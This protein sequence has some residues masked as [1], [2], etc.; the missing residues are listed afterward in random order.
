VS[1]KNPSPNT[2]PSTTTDSHPLNNIIIDEKKE[3]SNYNV[4]T[5]THRNYL[6]TEPVSIRLNSNI[7][8]GFRQWVKFSGFQLGRATEA[9]MLEYMKNHPQ[10]Q[11]RLSVT[12]N[13]SAYT[14]DVKDRLKNKIVSDKLTAAM[15]T[16]RHIRASGK[17]EASFK[18]QLQKLV[19]QAADLRKPDAELV[20]LLEEVEALL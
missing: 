15:A 11:I 6:S 3:S 19:L 5:T 20:K 17:S 2:P 14:P 13:L 16:L 18:R 7:I 8:D 12:Q 10:P 9:A 1:G 4:V